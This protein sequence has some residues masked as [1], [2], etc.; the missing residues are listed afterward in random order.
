MCVFAMH[1]QSLKYVNLL[2]QL[3]SPSVGPANVDVGDVGLVADLVQLLV[4]PLDL[5]AH[6]LRH[7]LQ[8]G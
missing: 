2:Q 7:F 1:F 3:V 8:V 6:G 4:L 5:A